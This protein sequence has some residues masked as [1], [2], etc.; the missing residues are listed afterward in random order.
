MPYARILNR[1]G[2]IAIVFDID[3]DAVHYCY[4]AYIKIVHILMMMPPARIYK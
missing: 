4:S 3:D 2:D 1:S